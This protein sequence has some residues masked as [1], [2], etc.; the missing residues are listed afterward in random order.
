MRITLAIGLEGTRINDFFEGGSLGRLWKMGGDDGDVDEVSVCRSIMVRTNSSHL[1]RLGLT[2]QK[3]RLTGFQY[4]LLY[5][6][7]TNQVDDTGKIS[8]SVSSHQT[9]LTP[10]ILQEHLSGVFY[11]ID[12]EPTIS[13]VTPQ[14][15]TIP[16]GY[17]LTVPRS[18]VK[19]VFAAGDVQAQDLYG[20][21]EQR[22]YE[23]QRGR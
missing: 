18:N 2:Q 9:T 1:L 8:S 11:P 5:L 20:T 13:F 21:A 7:S 16:G 10:L 14:F 4:S 19:G 22:M 17:I 6:P 3:R 12:H 15:Q 23:I